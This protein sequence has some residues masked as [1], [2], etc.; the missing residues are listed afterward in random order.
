MMMS[1]LYYIISQH[2]VSPIIVSTNTQHTQLL[3][4]ECRQTTNIYTDGQFNVYSQARPRPTTASSSNMMASPKAESLSSSN[5]KLDLSSN[6]NNLVA[7][8]PPYTSRRNDYHEG[9]VISSKG[10]NYECKPFP[11][12]SWCNIEDYAPGM[13]TFWDMA[14][15]VS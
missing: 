11:Q 7:C 12:T 9:E 1:S 15:T 14:W 6:N 5:S 13:S 8:G 2:N 10:R 4:D 3:D